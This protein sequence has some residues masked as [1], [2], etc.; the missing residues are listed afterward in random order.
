MDGAAL[1]L[2]MGVTDGLI[3]LA[4]ALLVATVLGTALRRRAGRFRPGSP[5]TAAKQG[6]A[7][8]LTAP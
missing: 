4:A 8:N 2:S 6:R 7:E 5:G 3:A 1:V